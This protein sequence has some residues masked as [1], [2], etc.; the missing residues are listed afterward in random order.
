MKFRLIGGDNIFGFFR[1]VERTY[2]AYNP[3][4][5]NKY[6]FVFPSY[7]PLVEQTIVVVVD[8]SGSIGE[9]ELQYSLDLINSL[10]KQSEIYLVEI[11]TMIQRV[12]RVREVE[13][14]FSF[15]GRGG[16]V[17]TDLERLPQF[18]PARDITACII[19]TDGYVDAFPEKKPLP[20]AKWIGIT[21]GVIPE[22]SPNWIKWFKVE[23]VI[24]DSGK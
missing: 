2:Y 16:T 17:F 18:L 9:E 5:A 10:V 15:K 13:E 7:R 4:N 20:R 11:D 6:G 12:I 3:L 14:K 8:T 19:L 22:N 23:R 1:E 24:E 21:T